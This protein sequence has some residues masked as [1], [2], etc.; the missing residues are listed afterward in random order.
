MVKIKKKT[1]KDLRN[2]INWGIKNDVRSK[3]YYS[4]H[5]SNKEHI[6]QFDELGK[7]SLQGNV[8]TLEAFEVEVE[9]EITEDTVIPR[10][11]E[12]RNAIPSKSTEWQDLK[13]F[14]SY[15]YANHSISEFKD[16]NSAA[17]YILNDDMTMTLI[18]KDGEI[19][20]D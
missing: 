7:I 19:I 14:K 20:G 4:C 18:W 2:L 8:S 3:K 1:Y 17:I 12:V 5:H 16:K 15:L 9:V 13:L 10:L 6:L 11:L